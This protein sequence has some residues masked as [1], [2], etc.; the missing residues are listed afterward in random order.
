M[1]APGAGYNS[2]AGV[3]VESTFGTPVAL[4]DYIEI[5]DESIKVQSPPIAKASLRGPWHRGYFQ[6]RK[7]V[8]GD[9]NTEIFFE[10]HERFL[11]QAFGDPVT[12]VV[13]AGAV[14][15]HLFTPADVLPPGLTL[16]INRD[17]KYFRYP[18]TKINQVAFNVSLD[19]VAR[20]VYS[21][22]CKDETQETVPSPSFPAEL[23][24]V[25]HE[26]VL[27]IDDVDFDVDVFDIS[28]GNNLSAERFKLGSRLVKE[29]VRNDIGIVEGSFTG[30]FVDSVQY[31]KYLAGTP[32]NLKL[33]ITSSVGIGVSSF[34]TFTIE[35]PRAVYTGETPGVAGAGIIPE[36][37]PFQGFRSEDL[38][39]PA[40]RVTLR[41][42]L[43]GPF[44]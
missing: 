9:L 32:V 4:Q 19:Q 15:D 31:D 13:E 25:F 26:A 35:V 10:G 39:T 8:S 5:I 22:V 7:I 43:A 21:C 34:Y 18:G 1:P 36:N 23:L 16:G 40:F 42:T 3:G 6:G 24:P 30:E 27:K 33:I 11:K 29:P 14:F 20:A 28:V 12:S 44:N 37:F 2:W 38:A 17:T 41:N